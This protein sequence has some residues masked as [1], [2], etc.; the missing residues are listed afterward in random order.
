[1]DV[2]IVAEGDLQTFETL[3]TD[4]FQLGFYAQRCPGKDKPNEDTVGVL[5]QNKTA[6]LAIADGVGGSPNGQIASRVTITSLIQCIEKLDA[7]PKDLTGIRQPLVETIERVNLELL[8]DYVGALTTLTACV[9]H[10]GVLQ[11]IQIG[12]SSLIVCGQKGLLKHKTLEQSPV[13]LAVAAGV[14]KEPEALLHPERHLVSNVLGDSEMHF[15]IGPRIELACYDTVLLASD[16]LFDNFITE[17]LVE[18]IRKQSLEEVLDK[19]TKLCQ[20]MRG[21]EQSHTLNKIDD[22]SFIVCRLGR[23]A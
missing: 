1:M 11:S 9:I 3:T 15:V 6:I 21:D 19:L 12:D 22:V 2:R 20:A 7:L 5:T 23:G 17:E 14:L 18:I 10:D 16:G 13:G 4:N 8:H